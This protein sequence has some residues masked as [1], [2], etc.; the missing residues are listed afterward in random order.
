[1]KSISFVLIAMAAMTLS[2]CY[3]EVEGGRPVHHFGRHPRH[4]E[5]IEIRSQNNTI[6]NDSLQSP[7]NINAGK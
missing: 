7:S 5:R 2:S 1:M 6:Q 3:V 4:E